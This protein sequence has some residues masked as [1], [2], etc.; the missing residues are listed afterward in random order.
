MED[1]FKKQMEDDPPKKIEDD[2]KKKLKKL[3][4]TS[5]IIEM[6]NDL[7]KEEDD[8]KNARRPQQ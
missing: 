3:K 7:K 4:T 1:D 8:L 2:I 6:E 5:T